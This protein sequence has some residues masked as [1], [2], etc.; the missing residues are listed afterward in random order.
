M[1]KQ[2]YCQSLYIPQRELNEIN[3]IL[4]PIKQKNC[5]NCN[6]RGVIAI[7]SV[8]FQD[9]YHVDFELSG[10]DGNVP[11]IPCVKAALFHNKQVVSK[12]QTKGQLTGEWIFDTADSTYI[13]AVQPEI[14]NLHIKYI[15]QIG[16]IESKEYDSPEAFIEAVENHQPDGPQSTDTMVFI[17]FNDAEKRFRSMFDAVNYCRS[18]LA[19]NKKFVC[20]QRLWIREDVGLE[21]NL[22]FTAEIIPN[23]TSLYECEIIDITKNILTLR[24]VM[25]VEDSGLIKI[26]KNTLR[27][28]Q[29]GDI[30]VFLTEQ[31]EN[32]DIYHAFLSENVQN[33]ISCL[34]FQDSYHC[35]EGYCENIEEIK[36]KTDTLEAILELLKNLDTEQ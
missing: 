3:R 22:D 25:P 29:G 1:R 17:Y 30:S 36:R 2:R 4:F 28:A 14:A 32:E 10:C 9:G 34:C 21:S 16:G 27:S 13:V 35:L 20:G 8:G 24:T 7:D 18:A 19:K 31:D 12:Y 6:E 5:L 11:N 26:F 15:N 33:T 23:R